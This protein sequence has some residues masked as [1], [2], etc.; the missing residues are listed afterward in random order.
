MRDHIRELIAK[1]EADLPKTEFEEIMRIAAEDKSVISLGPGEPDFDTPNN[2]RQATKKAVDKGLTHYSTTN[3]VQELREEISKKLQKVNGINANPDDEIIV[4]TGSSE[5]IFL[6]SIVLVEPN[7]KV[8]VPNPGYIN[9]IP[10]TDLMGGMPISIKLSHE[11]NFDYDIEQI[12]KQINDKTHVMIIN[13]PSN[14]TGRVLKRKNIEE[15]ADIVTEHN[16]VVF[17]DEAYESFVYGSNEH[18]SLASLN[19]MH[20]RVLSFFTFS[21][22]YA[23]AGY[24]IGYA[25]GSNEIIKAMSKLRLYSTLSS[26]VFVQE[27]AIE[28][29]RGPQ[30]EVEKMKKEYERRGRMLHRRLTEMG[31]WFKCEEPEG[32]FYMF[33]SIKEFGMTSTHLAHLLLEKAKVLV[34]PGTEFGE[35]GEGYLR[36]SYATSYEKI[37]EAMDRIENWLRNFK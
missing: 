28:A 4:T 3:G 5:A 27:A 14:P 19:G 15:L 35:H 16:M 20:N 34:V 7:D 33:P 17:S 32:A 23:M 25:V 18:I 12:K 8:I 10:L 24:R 31:E 37:Q 9:Y 36:M 11:N 13:S 26:P 2:I 29:L 30:D 1:R 21:K 6:A 22:T